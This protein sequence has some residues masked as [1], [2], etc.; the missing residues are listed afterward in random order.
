MADIFEKCKNY[1]DAKL[2]MRMGIY[3]YFQPIESAQGPEVIL[4]GKSI[5]WPVPITTWAWPT[6]PK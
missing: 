1:K 6:I 3:G 5:L 2:A 4:G